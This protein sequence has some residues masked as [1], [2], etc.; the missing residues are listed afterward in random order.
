MRLR[1]AFIG[2]LAGI[3]S[4]AILGGLAFRLEY[5]MEPERGIGLFGPNPT[6]VTLLGVI[7]VG[8]LGGVVGMIV[9]IS[10]ATKAR[11]AIIGLIFG[12]GAVVWQQANAASLGSS[13]LRHMFIV[14]SEL[15]GLPLIGF[16]VSAIVERVHSE[17]SESS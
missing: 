17:R 10:R 2:S 14:S 3:A 6:L 13:A 7:F 15:L 9:G 8:L 12:L 11:A 4:G 16:I 1:R 5:S